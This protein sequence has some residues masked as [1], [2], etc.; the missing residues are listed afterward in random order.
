MISLLPCLPDNFAGVCNYKGSIVPVVC[1]EGP[2]PGREE[3][4]ARQMV[5]VLRHQKYFRGNRL[6]QELY[7]TQIGVDEQIKG[8]E[9]QESG[10]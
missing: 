3:A 7:L 1:Q 6:N 5:L 2:A 8:P 9:Q 4:D 10:L